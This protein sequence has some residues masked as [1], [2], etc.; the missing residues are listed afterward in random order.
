MGTAVTHHHIIHMNVA[1]VTKGLWNHR[2]FVFSIPSF[3][4]I[5][6]T[7]PRSIEFCSHV[8]P[9]PRISLVYWTRLT[10]FLLSPRPPTPLSIYIIYFYVCNSCTCSEDQYL[11]EGN[12]LFTPPS[13]DGKKNAVKYK[14]RNDRW[15][16]LRRSTSVWPTTELWC[17]SVAMS[18][19]ARIAYA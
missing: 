2:D 15:I 18:C 8:L 13:P 4:S 12:P 19:T 3:P 17:D 7:S 5:P 9:V 11:F 10:C 16:T 14:T 6:F 1:P